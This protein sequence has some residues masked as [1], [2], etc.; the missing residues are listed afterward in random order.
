MGFNL[1]NFLTGA[2]RIVAKTNPVTAILADTLLP[3]RIEDATGVAP[4]MVGKILSAIRM[5]PELLAAQNAHEAEMAKLKADLETAA[6][7]LSSGNLLGISDVP[8]EPDGTFSWAK[9][10]LGS[11]RRI[12]VTLAVVTICLLSL[13]VGIRA[14]VVE[15][16]VADPENLTV[17]FVNLRWVVVGLAGAYATKY[18]KGKFSA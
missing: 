16:A 17:V 15:K 10:L 13:I 5:D 11:P 2:V 7:E 6:M 3:Q 9:A 4:G 12:G 14:I 8:A 18:F 1:K